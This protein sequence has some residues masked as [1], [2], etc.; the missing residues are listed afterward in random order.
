MF[1][2]LKCIDLFQCLA[3]TT[4][5]RCF[6]ANQTLIEFTHFHGQFSSQ[7]CRQRTKNILWKPVDGSGL[8]S[9]QPSQE[10]RATNLTLEMIFRQPTVHWAS[11]V[12]WGG[13]CRTAAGGADDSHKYYDQF[14]LR[15]RRGN[16][17]WIQRCNTRSENNMRSSHLNQEFLWALQKK[18]TV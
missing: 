18:A 8:S 3:K 5:L 4:D 2:K 7:N 10:M 13:Q 14:G 1:Q 6:V 12:S 9:L 15:A 17:F 16:M 11:R